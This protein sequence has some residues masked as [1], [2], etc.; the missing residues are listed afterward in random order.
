MVLLLLFCSTR[1][2]FGHTNVTASWYPREPSHCTGR[3]W[4][5]TC[6]T[7]TER[8]GHDSLCTYATRCALFSLWPCVHVSNITGSVFHVAGRPCGSHIVQ[9]AHLDDWEQE[10]CS[11][12]YS[13]PSYDNR[14][15]TIRIFWPRGR[16][17]V[18]TRRLYCLGGSRFCFCKREAPSRGTRRETLSNQWG[19]PLWH[20]GTQS[21]D[22]TKRLKRMGWPLR[23]SEAS[24]LFWKMGKNVCM[25]HFPFLTNQR[26]KAATMRCGCN[27]HSLTIMVTTHGEKS[28]TNGFSLREDL[29]TRLNKERAKQ[30]KK[31]ARSR[32]NKALVP[33]EAQASLC[34]F[35]PVPWTHTHHLGSCYSAKTQCVHVP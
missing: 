11:H 25:V 21:L 17:L 9:K 14:I 31:C 16:L 28:M 34:S 5:L 6:V 32:H 7:K 13:C 12:E 23:I 29:R 1:E 35:P 26:I 20:R 27:W 22:R 10:N 3:C 8:K 24:R 18:L 33:D 2:M 4:K 30:L 15:P 19:I